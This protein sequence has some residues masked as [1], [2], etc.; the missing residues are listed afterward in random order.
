MK[1]IF[2]MI[3]ILSILIWGS[4]DVNATSGRLSKDSIIKCNGIIYGKHGDGYWHVAEKRG[5]FYYAAGDPLRKNPCSVN[6]ATKKKTTKTTTTT[7]KT[8]NKN[9]DIEVIPND[10]KV[11]YEIKNNS[12]LKIGDNKVIVEVIAENSSVCIFLIVNW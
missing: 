4:I 2:Y 3:A 7:K 10:D 12:E 1:K 8:T 5:G 9:I 6:V 11:K